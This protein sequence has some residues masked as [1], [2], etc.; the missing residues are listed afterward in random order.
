M[1]TVSGLTSSS[2]VEYA[3]SL[4]ESAKMKRSLFSIGNAIQEGDLAGAQ[5]KLT[6]LFKAYPQYA[7]SAADTTSDPD[8]INS[9]FQAVADAVSKQDIEGAK[10]AW[11]TV[12]DDLEAA[13]V[14][15]SDSA[16]DVAK[17]VANSK[18]AMNQSILD[19]VF[20]ADSGTNTLSTLL[21]SNATSASNSISSL[22]SSW[23]TYKANGTTSQT[24][25]NSTLANILD[26]SA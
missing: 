15:I 6:A 16:T 5:T 3:T 7:A 9:H 23:V 11:A 21:S 17:L 8:S 25:T 4:A 14:T 26:T 24:N 22:V 12:T 20:G 13:G 10:A 1:S 19:A 2:S 18:A